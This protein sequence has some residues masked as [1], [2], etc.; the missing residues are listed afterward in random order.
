[1]VGVVGG[2]SETQLPGCGAEEAEGREG[3]RCVGGETH[4]GGEEEEEGEQGH[5][6]GRGEKKR[7]EGQAIVCYLW[8][9]RDIEVEGSLS[10]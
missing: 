10:F 6:R 2:R 8:R 5:K 9:L 1:M 7:E 3:R 4:W